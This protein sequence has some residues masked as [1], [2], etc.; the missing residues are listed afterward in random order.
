MSYEQNLNCAEAFTFLYSL[1]C[2]L[3]IEQFPCVEFFKLLFNL[4]WGFR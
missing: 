4:I 2:A 1:K 3:T